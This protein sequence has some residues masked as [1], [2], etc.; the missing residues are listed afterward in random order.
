MV[1][2]VDQA[3]AILGPERDEGFEAL[4]Q[5]IEKYGLH[6]PQ[7]H[8]D[9]DGAVLDGRRRLAALSD[10]GRDAEQLVQYVRHDCADDKERLSIMARANNRRDLS[11]EQRAKWHQFLRDNGLTFREIAE[12]TGVHN[13]TVLRDLATLEDSD[14]PV[15]APAPR[16]AANA[17]VRSSSEETAPAPIPRRQDS[18]GRFLPTK[19]T[20]E[21]EL[22]AR[23]NQVKALWKKKYGAGA[24]A[25]S[26]N[27]SRDTVLNDLRYLGFE[28]ERRPKSPPVPT[29]AIKA[30]VPPPPPQP[31]LWR[32]SS[33]LRL[34]EEIVR[35]LKEMNGR[36]A[37]AWECQEAWEAGD[38][39]WLDKAAQICTDAMAYLNDM[40]SS[41]SD[42]AEADKQ[43]S[44]TDYRDDIGKPAGFRP[45]L[46]SD[47]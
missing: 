3:Q 26:L 2:V 33:E 11:R 12:M 30:S 28:I 27:V 45:R 42:R 22:N 25:E 15:S 39:E 40:K 34:V 20:T 10:L 43:T 35:G 1:N 38:Q 13:T 18:R 17:A 21:A 44:S 5:S 46:V 36:A 31:P 23:R 6:D 24:I 19:R 7:I 9:Q 47:G 37:F 32:R 8:V 41:A 16:T 29:S 14:P 4:K